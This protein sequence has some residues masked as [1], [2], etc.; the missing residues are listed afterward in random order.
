MPKTP[1]FSLLEAPNW[2]DYALL[3]SGDGL[4]L[5]RFGSYLFVRPEVQAM[6]SRALPEKEWA[7]AHAVFQPT[8]E[9]SGGHWQFK[10]KVAEKWEMGYPLTLP[11]PVPPF[12]EGKWGDEMGVRFW[13]MTTSGRHLG[14]FPECAT[15]WDWSA[16]LIYKARWPIKVL[17]LFGYTGLA[18]LAAAA[19]GA[20]VTHVDASKKSVA[21]ARD[22]QVLSGLAEK[23]VR[24]IVED[25]LKFAQREARRGNKYDCILLDPPKF[26]RGPKGEV[27]EIY[28]SLPKLLEACRQVLSDRPLFVITTVYA[29][30]ASALHVGQALGELMREF[31]GVV[32]SGELVTREQSAGRLLSQAVYARWSSGDE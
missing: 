32:E 14:V 16:D 1:T 22:N 31:G 12:S 6:W 20:Q 5:E 26:G 25:A 9:E 2:N 11:P 27:W 7:K 17:N 8:S 24:W 19:A 30:Q 15:H 28:K 23:P 3:D 4:K 13:A 10:K 29:V 21:W 18:T